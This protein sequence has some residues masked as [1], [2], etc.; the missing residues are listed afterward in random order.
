[1]SSRE[2]W[3]HTVSLNTRAADFAIRRRRN[4]IERDPA[5]PLYLR[6]QYGGLYLSGC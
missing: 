4:T 5:Q 3:G 2:V 1:M 6:T